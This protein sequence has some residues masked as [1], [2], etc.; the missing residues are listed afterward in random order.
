LQL[1]RTTWKTDKPGVRRLLHISWKIGKP[2]YHRFKIPGK[3][4]NQES[5]AVKPHGKPGNHR[6]IPPG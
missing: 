3:A 4:V 6:R 1:L 2:D 5:F